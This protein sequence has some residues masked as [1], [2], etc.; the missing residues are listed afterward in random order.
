MIESTTDINATDTQS[1]A[2]KK[3][4]NDPILLPD[5]EIKLPI[6][7]DKLH[8]MQREDK[9]CSN[10]IQQLETVKLSAR[11]PYYLEE[12]ILK[13]Y[14]DDH[15]QRFEV[16]VLPR[17]LAP[18][19]LRLAHEEMGHNGIPRNICLTEKTVLLERTKTNG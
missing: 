3:P 4:D 17:D 10:I 8:Q 13:R 5:E 7:D 6:E 1:V 2:P 11:N 16:I 14:V 15:K 18:I 9:F 19:T 12:G